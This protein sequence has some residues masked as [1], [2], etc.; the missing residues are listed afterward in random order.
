MAMLGRPTGKSSPANIRASA[1]LMETDDKMRVLET[2]LNVTE[3]SNRTLLEEVI[4]LQ[5]ELR[6]TVVSN[7]RS[8]RDEKQA[9]HQLDNSLQI[10]ND[11]IS[12]LSIHC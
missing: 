3:K 10:V 9:R 11:L 5:N 4:R 8:I 12:Q 2:R 1:D 6:T 7:E